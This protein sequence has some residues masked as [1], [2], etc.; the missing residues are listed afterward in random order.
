MQNVHKTILKNEKNKNKKKK[1]KKI[2]LA[3]GQGLGILRAKFPT[4]T[5]SVIKFSLLCQG[6][7][8]YGGCASAILDTES[9]LV[10]NE[11]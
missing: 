8:A 6:Q 3:A 1:R 5:Q 4:P 2:S 10:P 11:N 7:A 9:E